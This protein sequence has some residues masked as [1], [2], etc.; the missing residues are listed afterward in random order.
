MSWLPDDRKRVAWWTFS[1][2]MLVVFL[3]VLHAFVG[4]VVLGLFVYYGTRPAYQRL[5]T[6]LPTGGAA[7]ATLLL[8]TIPVVALVGYTVFVGFSE[9][10]ALTNTPLSS[11]ARYLPGTPENPTQA[12]ERL[13][14]IAGPGQN[15]QEQMLSTV[16]GVLGTIAG[17]LAHLSLSFMLAFFLL[18]DDHRVADW[19][20]E[21]IAAEDSTARAYVA[22][23]DEDLQKV[24]VGNLLTVF[25]VM[26]LGVVVY[27]ALN[28]IAPSGLGV[29]VPTLLAL[30][31]GV[32]TLVP[33]VVGKIVYVPV[34]AYI[35]YEAATGA[36]PLWFPVVFFAVC[37]VLLDL[38]P[39]AV[40][41]PYIAGRNLHGGLMVFAYIGGTMLFGWYG[42]FLGPLVAV[43]LVQLARIVVP[44]LVHGE[45]PSPDAEGA[46]SI[47]ADPQSAQRS[48]GAQADAGGSE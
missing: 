2:A 36:G 10:S 42:L 7:A 47:G 1:L 18:R 37:L 43:V 22:A 38:L 28:A 17:G 9:L 29:P 32:A 8:V 26:G 20:R 31:T 12:V 11:F 27:N 15:A 46:E 39:V 41:R 16:V 44:D 23:V 35:G 33:L 45:T 30:L 34:G 40:L 6:I 13:R 5:R 3:F 48:D 24:Y 25:A 14:Q 4:T 21:Q 19:F